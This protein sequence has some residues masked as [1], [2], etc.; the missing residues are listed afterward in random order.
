MGYWFTH[1]MVKVMSMGNSTSIRG[2]STAFSMPRLIMGAN[3]FPEGKAKGAAAA[4]QLAGSCRRK[5][6]FLLTDDFGRKI[7]KRVA[8]SLETTGFATRIWAG[9]QPEAPLDSVRECT[10]AM[11]EFAPD[12]IV[13]VGGGSVI[14]GAKAAWIQYVRPDIPD[15]GHITW[16]TPLSRPPSCAAS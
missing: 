7:A 13:A 6:A 8:A 3:V 2:L 4:N 10:V 12:L 5:Q 1:P 16:Y 14:D 9:A 15:L 11:A